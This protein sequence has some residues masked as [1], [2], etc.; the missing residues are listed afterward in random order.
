MRLRKRTVRR[1]SEAERIRK[2]YRQKGNPPHF[3]MMHRQKIERYIQAQELIVAQAGADIAGCVAAKLMRANST[4]YSPRKGDIYL[5]SLVVD[6]RFRRLGVGE[7]LVHACVQR[8]RRVGSPRVVITV[9]SA[10]RAMIQLMRKRFTLF[11]IKTTNVVTRAGNKMEYL[12]F[13]IPVVPN[14]GFL[15]QQ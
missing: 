4:R 9:S 7:V 12:D 13:E 10:N 11:P 3:S 14:H 2:L 1:L 6:Q 8:A 15:M 5:Q